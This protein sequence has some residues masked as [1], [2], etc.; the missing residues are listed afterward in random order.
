M[1]ALKSASVSKLGFGC[2]VG[3]VWEVFRTVE[4]NVGGLGLGDGGGGG[5]IVAFWGVVLCLEGSWRWMG[6]CQCPRERLRLE[7]G[8]GSGTT[9]DWS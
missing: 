8:T 4:K 3:S 7:G 6:C 2:A 9:L 1:G 5:G